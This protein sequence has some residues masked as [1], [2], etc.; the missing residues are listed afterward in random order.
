MDQ[1]AMKKAAALAAL[2]YVTDDSIIG[3]GTGST[4]NYFI[5]GLA[6]IKHRIEGAV[7]SS[8]ATAK[9][10]QALGIPVLDLTVVNDIPL[11]VDGTDEVDSQLCLLKGA[12]GAL[13]REKIIAAVAKTFICI[14]DQSKQVK[15]LGNAPLVIEVIPMARSYVARQIVRLQGDPVYRE[16]YTS[17]NGNVLLDVY[18]LKV[19]EPIRLEETLNNIEG[20]VSHGLFAKRRADLLLLGTLQGVQKI[21]V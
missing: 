13:T 20:V 14:A 17:D 10:L 8:T 12:G 21:K 19:V 1:N 18:N 9:H 5:E 16:G 6:T 7:A 11:Y 3:V 15:G 2:P 4:V